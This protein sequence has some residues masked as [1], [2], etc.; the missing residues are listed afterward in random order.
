MSYAPD[1]VIPMMKQAMG[2]NFAP[3]ELGQRIHD[4]ILERLEDGKIRPV[5][6]QVLGF[7]DVPAALTAMAKRE[8]MGRTVI[9][10]GD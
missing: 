10:I 4:G 2:W 3:S 8:T 5:I 6:G 9:Q 7:E 1:N